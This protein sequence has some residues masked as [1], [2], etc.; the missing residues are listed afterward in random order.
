MTKILLF[1]TAYLYVRTVMS[2]VPNRNGR[3]CPVN[4]VTHVG[5]CIQLSLSPTGTSCVHT[6][7]YVR[8]TLY[9]TVR[10]RDT[11]VHTY[12]RTCARERA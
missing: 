10:I 1:G 2:D 8:V 3:S 12:V 7:R 4:M 11:Y 5:V 9:R 6:V